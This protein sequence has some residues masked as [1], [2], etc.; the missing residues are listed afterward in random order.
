MAS[1]YFVTLCTK[2]RINHFG[3]IKNG[4][5]LLNSVGKKADKYWRSIPQYYDDTKLDEYIIMPNHIH[6][7]I[8]IMGDELRTGHYPV[9]T[10]PRYGL[11]SKIFNAFKN[12]VTKNIKNHTINN[13]AWQRSFYDHVI[14]NEN[15]FM[16]IR[17]YIQNNP[18]KWH[19]DEYYNVRNETQ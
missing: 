1:Y 19:L 3:S 4:E 13:F 9:P 16:R 12:A 18:S 17:Q 11:L 5:I 10:T 2:D 15:D 7:I 14:R 6:G 8:V